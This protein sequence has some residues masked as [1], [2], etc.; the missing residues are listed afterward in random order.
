M[1]SGVFE[2]CFSGDWN[3]RLER[4]IRSSV[5]LRCDM[6]Y[7]YYPMTDKVGGETRA[8]HLERSRTPDGCDVAKINGNGLSVTWCH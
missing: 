5:V 1:F 4:K 2:D 7:N 3:H 6:L 8:V